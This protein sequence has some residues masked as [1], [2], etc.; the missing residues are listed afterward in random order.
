L[1]SPC[2]MNLLLPS[3]KRIAMPSVRSL[4]AAWPGATGYFVLAVPTQLMICVRDAAQAQ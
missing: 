1:G 3:T 2:K 4:Q